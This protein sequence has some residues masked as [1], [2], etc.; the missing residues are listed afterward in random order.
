MNNF[1]EKL[2]S[3]LLETFKFTIDFLNQSGLNWWV[4]FG[5]MLGTVRHKGYIPWDDDI[6]I[7]MP[8]KDYEQLLSMK[9]SLPKPL[10]I[11]D[12]TDN[13]YNYPFAKIYN[14]ETTICE[15]PQFPFVIGS[16]IDIF[17]LDEVEQHEAEKKRAEYDS[18][19]RKAVAGRYV[20]SLETFIHFIK[21]RQFKPLVLYLVSPLIY[22]GSCKDRMKRFIEFHNE[23]VSQSKGEYY[24]QLY[25]AHLAF[26]K[27]DFSSTL[28]MPF[29][30]LTVNIPGGY[31][32]ILRKI[33]GDYMTLPPED[34]RVP[35]HNIY[36]VNL[37]ER[38]TLKEIRERRKKGERCVY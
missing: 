17:P 20:Y 26:K 8:R 14:S 24:F 38:L 3:S 9:K 36:Y 18:A 4:A 7:Y 34:Q 19:F 28:Q 33:Y 31:D 32:N 21:L 16:W 15:G 35:R 30:N 11:V 10:N 12:F 23:M 1:E 37:K 27:E 13:G 22:R 6:D 5:T 29:E 25:N 2:K